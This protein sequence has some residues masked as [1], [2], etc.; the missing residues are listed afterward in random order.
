MT[1]EQEQRAQEPPDGAGPDTALQQRIQ[2]TIQPVVAN[3]RQ[4]M[5]ESLRRQLEHQDQPEDSALPTDG[6][7][8]P[9]SGSPEEPS[10]PQ[11]QADERNG[12]PAAHQ[13]REPAGD[14]TE[15]DTGDEEEGIGDVLSD[16]GQQVP[17]ILLHAL[18]E[19]GEPWLQSMV[20]AALD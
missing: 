3:F 10:A 8:R 12:G 15:A 19:Q 1:T 6:P 11:L 9:D 13:T 5:A 16:M 17:G 18:A 14:E 4:Q 2:Q 20:D 7:A